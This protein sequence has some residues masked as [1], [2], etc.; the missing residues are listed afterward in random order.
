[1]LG[2][3]YRVLIGSFHTCYHDWETMRTG[4]GTND[5]GNRWPIVY[6]RCKKCGDWTE[7]EFK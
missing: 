4:V 1:M 6:L 3:L 7:R 5:D 2:W